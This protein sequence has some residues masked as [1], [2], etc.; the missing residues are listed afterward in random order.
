[1]F[2][3]RVYVLYVLTILVGWNIV[4]YVIVSSLCHWL[5]GMKGHNN[6]EKITKS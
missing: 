4:P 2:Y 3:L 6:E 5:N 1:M